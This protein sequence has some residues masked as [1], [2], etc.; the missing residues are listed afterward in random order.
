MKR[1]FG[2]FYFAL[3][4]FFLELVCWEGYD[5]MIGFMFGFRINQDGIEFYFV[6]ILSFFPSFFL[7]FV[8]LLVRLDRI[9]RNGY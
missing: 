6:I 9:G 5:I 4:G 3:F 1:V 8:F 7:P 2:F